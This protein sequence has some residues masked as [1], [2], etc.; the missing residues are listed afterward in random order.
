M[1][2]AI[3]NYSDASSVDEETLLKQELSRLQRQYRI[4][5]N[6]RK[7]NCLNAKHMM[8]KQKTAI[9][10]LEGEMNEIETEM[11]LASSCK[12]RK[13]DNEN[14]EDLQ[15]FMKG[16]DEYATKIAKEAEEIQSLDRQISETEEKIKAQ[17]RAMGGV[18]N[19]H[20]RH[21]TTQHTIRVLENRLNKATREF[22]EMLAKNSKL[23]EQ[24]QHLRSQRSVFDGIHKRLYKDLVS[25]KREQLEL[26]EQS[27]MAFDQRD[28][29]EQKMATL[30]DRN[31]KDIAQYN[32]EY[33]ELMRQLDH[34]TAL[35]KFLL[36]KAQER[37]EMAEGRANERK[38]N[39]EEKSER[40]A[41]KVLKE[42]LTAFKDIQKITG[43]ER[44]EKLVERFVEM[45]DQNFAMFSYVNEIN[46]QLEKQNDSIRALENEIQIYK[47]DAE[48]T[49]EQKR[50]KLKEIEAVY[51]QK[52]SEQSAMELEMND[53]ER[54]LEQLRIGIKSIFENTGCSMSSIEN[55]LGNQ[56]EV[57][58]QNIMDYLSAI[59]ET[60]ND[61]VKRHIVM[62]DTEDDP[63]ARAT[64]YRQNEETGG[65]PAPEDAQNTQ[66]A[67]SIV[68]D[69]IMDISSIRSQ[70]AANVQAREKE[71]LTTQ[72]D[73]K[74]QIITKDN[75]R[76]KSKK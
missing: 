23:R 31:Q 61:L 25:K 2:R 10:Q 40:Q 45:E 54:L 22:N 8:M 59:E 12:N 5:E 32:M 30:A 41:E 49:I 72:Q 14:S 67:T 48:E 47:A 16:Q 17:H 55:R 75:K 66:E 33:K 15:S 70:A 68:S 69:E 37:T 18:H 24:I 64:V 34:D 11:K 29:A 74:P 42:Y 9:N 26:I 43:E 38:K 13:Q 46:D 52:S 63:I 60:A 53:Q 50:A 1:N 76:N 27:T 39:F 56:S 44:T 62:A 65:A 20:Q 3:S 28:E 19:S 51:H 4:M 73:G 58:D 6:E 7:T 57:T 21:V 71:R 35:K 36:D